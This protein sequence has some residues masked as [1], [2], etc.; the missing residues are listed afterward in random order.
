MFLNL[1][2]NF[3]NNYQLGLKFSWSKIGYF[4]NKINDFEKLLFSIWNEWPIFF[5]IRFVL[6]IYSSSL[7]MTS[8]NLIFV[9]ANQF[10]NVEL[11]DIWSSKMSIFAL[12]E[13]RI[14]HFWSFSIVLWI[15]I[16]HLNDW[17]HE[18]YA[19]NHHDRLASIVT[20]HF[21]YR[22][23]D[24]WAIWNDQMNKSKSKYYKDRAPD[25]EIA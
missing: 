17:N 23:N 16:N 12:F 8:D 2:G 15:I 11:V 14:V 9:I 21:L 18:I 6:F 3:F 20:S 5:Q 13:F 19:C 10:K 4:Y 22:W 25:R 24:K 1:G 7:V